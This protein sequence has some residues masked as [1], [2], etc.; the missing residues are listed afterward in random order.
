MRQLFQLDDR[1]AICAEFVRNGSKLADIGTDHAYLP[2]WLAKNG[3]IS[4]A[5]AADI[6]PKP[7]QRG[8]NNIEKYEAGNL[9]ST[10]I[11]DGLVSFSSDDADDIV[12]AGMGAELIISII[13]KTPWLKQSSKRLILQPMTRA[14][15]LREYLLKEGFEILKEKACEHNGKVYSVMA[16][17]YSGLHLSENI[18]GEA[19]YLG[20]LDMTLPLS[21]KYALQVLNK[22]YLK[23]NG[24]EHSGADTSE[25]DTVIDEVKGRCTDGKSY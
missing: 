22:L 5:I 3:K 14:Q 25:L 21:R 19:K 16:V 17:E 1:L 18:S 7:L 9:V 6:N 12:I 24:M 8:M 20:K 10:R 15:L 4:S 13:S 11:S 2:V 23:R